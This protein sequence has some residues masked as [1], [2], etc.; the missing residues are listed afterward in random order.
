MRH[1]AAATLAI[2]FTTLPA[3]AAAIALTDLLAALPA[4]EQQVEAI[5]VARYAT[6]IDD[7]DMT[8]D[9]H[10]VADRLH[11]Q[12]VDNQAKQEN[13]LGG[14][15]FGLDAPAPTLNVYVVKRVSYCARHRSSLAGCSDQPGRHLY[16][17]GR[18]LLT[19][20]GDELFAHELA[21]ALGL[22]GH[23]GGNNLMNGHI[24]NGRSALDREQVRTIRESPLIQD[25]R[26]VI[27]MIFVTD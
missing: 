6:G 15:F 25:G 3:S 26:L 16:F 1:P 9:V 4:L 11:H 21:H 20:R 13:L 5:L 18:E 10:S 12:H 2:L 24:T 22:V 19:P 17:E 7:I 8:S 27:R 14:N 23:V